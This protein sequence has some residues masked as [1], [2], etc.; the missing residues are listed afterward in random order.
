MT[1]HCLLVVN[2]RGTVFPYWLGMP[3]NALPLTRYS[4]KWKVTTYRHTA[5]RN[6]FH[7]TSAPMPMTA[8]Y[9]LDPQDRDTPID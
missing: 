6:I 4:L 2:Q 3:R 5:R 7:W 8:G 1:Y 9:S